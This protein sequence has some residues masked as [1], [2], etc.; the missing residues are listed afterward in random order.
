M[1]EAAQKAADRLE[2]RRSEYLRQAI[3]RA[4]RADG[5]DP[6]P[7]SRDTER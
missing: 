5:F 4:L 3:V 2:M 6:A 7:P 1:F